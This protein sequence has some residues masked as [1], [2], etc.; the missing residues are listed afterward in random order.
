MLSVVTNIDISSN[1]LMREVPEELSDCFKL[2]SLNLSNNKLC[3]KI[4]SHFG[5]LV[6]IIDFLDLSS[7][8]LTGEIPP[9]LGSLSNLQ[10][11]NLSR[12]NLTGHI[13]SS[14]VGMSSLSSIDLSYNQLEGPIPVWLFPNYL[15][16]CHCYGLYT[17]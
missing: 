4:P 14:M 15:T 11:L 8:F 6:S 2:E 1:N 13:P 5:N 16:K 3:G 17:I 9:T 7:N 10:N 12:N